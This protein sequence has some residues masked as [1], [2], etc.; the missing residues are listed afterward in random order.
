MSMQHQQTRQPTQQPTQ[1]FDAEKWLETV[2]EQSWVDPVIERQANMIDK[3]T[4]TFN[5]QVAQAGGKLFEAM[6]VAKGIAIMQQVISEE[7]L[8]LLM[9]LQGREFGFKVDRTYTRDVVKDAACY[10]F[11]DGL[12]PFGN[13]WN[14]IGGKYMAVLNGWRRKVNDLKLENLKIDLGEPKPW[15]Q[16]GLRVDC[17]AT[18]QRNGQVETIRQ[19]FSLKKDGGFSIDNADGRLHRKM[20]KAIYL[21]ICGNSFAGLDSDEI[22]AGAAAAQQI[23]AT[24]PKAPSFTD[25]QVADLKLTDTVRDHYSAGLGRDAVIATHERL[26]GKRK[27]SELSADEL[28]LLESHI[29]AGIAEAAKRNANDNDF[30]R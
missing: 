24:A 28:A 3:V 6:I 15:G 14:I 20:Y 18:W 30:E 17:S 23:A 9:Q 25:R 10:A 1:E 7:M 4:K 26:F 16:F 21:K 12:Q 2:L 13:E 11:L 29:R 5:V 22:E 19:Q 27:R 8:E